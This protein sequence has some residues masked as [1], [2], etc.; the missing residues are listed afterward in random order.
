MWL[1]TLFSDT[2]ALISAATQFILAILGAVVSLQED[3]AKKHQP[4]ILAL[5]ISVGLIGVCATIQQS[6]KAA[7]E[8][9]TANT[10][11]KAI[12]TSTQEIARLTALN[13]KLQE[14]L[15]ESNKRIITLSKQTIDTITGGDSFCYMVIRDRQ[16]FVTVVHQGKYPLYGVSARVVDVNK[17]RTAKP[18]ALEATV[19][20]IKIPVGNLGS[21]SAQMIKPFTFT[22]SDTG[23]QDFNIFFSNDRGTFWNQFLRA[24]LIDGEWVFA[25]KVAKDSVHD[26][27][28]PVLYERIDKKFP[29]NAHGKIDWEESKK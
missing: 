6:I 25:T 26:P 8:T 13:T 28:Q 17:V 9:A 22:F 11:L 21:N 2:W 12:N 7:A 4:L 19:I 24:R 18:E 15:L 23:Q 29:R 1:Q 5:F 27:K 10:Q 3:W 16:P 20:G 14:Q